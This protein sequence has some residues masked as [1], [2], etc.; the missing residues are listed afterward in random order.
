MQSTNRQVVVIGTGGTIAGTAPDAASHTAYRS[1]VISVE[2]LVAAVPG[3]RGRGL[4]TLTLARLDSSDMDHAT[5]ARLANGI[6]QQLARHDVVGVVVTHGT[7]TLEETAYFL[8]RCVA[9]HKPIVLTAAMRP[10]SAPSPDGPQN[11]IDAVQVAFAGGLARGVLAVLG[12]CIFAGAEL[13]KVHGYRVDAFSSGDAGPIGVLED[14]HLRCFRDWPL[15]ELHAAASMLGEPARWPVVEIVTSHAGAR[16]ETI[17]TLVAAGA[18]GIVIAGTGNG[19]V[20]H[21]LLAAAQRAQAA[22]V[23]VRRSSR[24]ILSGVV[25]ASGQLASVPS[26]A[27]LTPVQARIELMLDLI[28]GHQ[29]G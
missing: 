19:S 24:C 8:H 2:D 6:G 5:W 4:E 22:G 18:Q 14:G 9:A 21:S 29:S 25:G 16:G 12:G 15:P 10:A 13:R 3:L 11:L 1:A 23:A 17:D 7:D 27:V 26:A 28:A 20:H